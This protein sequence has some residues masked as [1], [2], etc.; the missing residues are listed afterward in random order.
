MVTITDIIENLK[1][2]EWGNAKQYA[3]FDETMYQIF[4]NFKDAPLSAFQ[5]NC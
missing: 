2:I 5:K 1:R 3:N 4:V